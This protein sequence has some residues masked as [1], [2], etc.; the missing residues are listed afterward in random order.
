MFNV[1]LSEPWRQPGGIHGEI[2]RYR[3]QKLYFKA[4]CIWRIVL[5]LVITPKV[6]LATGI[7]AWALVPG[8]C[9]RARLFDRGRA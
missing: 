8:Y 1:P 4:T 3:N 6:D 9:R 5:A 2:E 7:A